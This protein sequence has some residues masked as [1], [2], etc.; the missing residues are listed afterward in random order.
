MERIQYHRV[1]LVVVGCDDGA[2]LVVET[3]IGMAIMTGGGGDVSSVSV[4]GTTALILLGVVV[5]L[6]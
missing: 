1:Q 2:L 3:T 6:T 4:L 5:L